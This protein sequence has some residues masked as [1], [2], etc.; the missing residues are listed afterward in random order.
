MAT[1]FASL[2]LSASRF[3]I[4]SQAGR[5]FEEQVR[6]DTG[7]DYTQAEAYNTAIWHIAEEA[8][9]R[10]FSALQGM[11]TREVASGIGNHLSAYL[12]AQEPGGVAPLIL[13]SL[14]VALGVGVVALATA[15]FWLPVLAIK[16]AALVHTYPQLPANMLITAAKAVIQ[17]KSPANVAR[18]MAI[19]FGG[20]VVQKPLEGWLGVL[21]THL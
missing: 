21:K 8:R 1:S 2:P 14:C 9:R 5:I 10:G 3:D 4:Y 6:K 16:A 17:G 7:T 19:N 12:Q 11:S 13:A 20:V 15:H 18:D